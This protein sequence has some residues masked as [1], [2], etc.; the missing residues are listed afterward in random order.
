MQQNTQN[1]SF[2]VYSNVQLTNNKNNTGISATS[3]PSTCNIPSTLNADTDHFT[4]YFISID[5]QIY[6]FIYR[7]E[8]CHATCY[9]TL[10]IHHR[11][12]STMFISSHHTPTSSLTLHCIAL[13]CMVP[14]GGA[15]DFEVVFTHLCTTIL[16]ISPTQ[17]S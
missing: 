12:Q 1:A 2:I 17:D 3:E 11:M 7:F 10:I 5:N 6:P 13:H 15:T 16:S 14:R 4:T 9:A 8:K